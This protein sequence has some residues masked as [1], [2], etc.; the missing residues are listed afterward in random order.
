LGFQAIASTSHWLTPFRLEL[1][2]GTL[3]AIV[4]QGGSDK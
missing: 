2:A 3:N 1:Q 4:A